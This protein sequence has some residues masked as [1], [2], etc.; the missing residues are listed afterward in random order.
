MN[1]A[2]LKDATDK[3]PEVGTVWQVTVG[4]MLASHDECIV[5]VGTLKFN[6]MLYSEAAHWVWACFSLPVEDQI[7]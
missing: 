6:F 4:A 3:G 5:R 7:L 2:W 1:W